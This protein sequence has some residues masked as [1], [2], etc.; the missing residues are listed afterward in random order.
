VVTVGSRAAAA[1]RTVAPGYQVLHTT[2]TA[3]FYRE[4]EDGMPPA[5]RAR[6]TALFLDQPADR[7]LLALN[8]ALPQMDRIGVLTSHAD[9]P[10][11][12]TLIVA[13]HEYAIAITVAEVKEQRFLITRLEELLRG[14][15]LLLVT[16]DTEIYN[17]YSLRN[18]LLTAYRQRKPV[19]G[20]SA[21]YVKAGA[22]LAVHSTPVTI[23]QDAAELVGWFLDSGR[24]PGPRA[25]LRFEVSINHQVARSLGLSTR[26]PDAQVLAERLRELERMP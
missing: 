1:A 2:I 15:D 5:E 20:V 7:Q 19:I 26:L 4:F 25:P 12:G 21:A 14:T 8:S 6:H 22:L 24:L 11:L 13:A 3:R 9:D 16:P 17:S 23:G 18:V 10:V